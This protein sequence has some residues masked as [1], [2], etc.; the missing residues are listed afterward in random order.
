KDVD[1]SIAVLAG[2]DSQLQRSAAG[3]I[4]A[5]GEKQN[6][7]SAGGIIDVPK[8]AET[9][10]IDCIENSGARNVAASVR[11]E[12]AVSDALGERDRIVRPGLRYLRQHAEVDDERL[13][14]FLTQQPLHVP[15]RNGPVTRTSFLHGFAR[16][17]QNAGA[18]GKILLHAKVQHLTRR[19][20]VIENLQLTELQIVDRETVSIGRMKGKC[21]LI[22]R[23]AETERR[24]I[25]C[26]FLTSLGETKPRADSERKNQQA[27]KNQPHVHSAGRPFC[28]QKNLRLSYRRAPSSKA[29]DLALID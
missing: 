1:G 9:S 6:E 25:L 10:P 16:I 14:G 23:H 20:A 13:V 19:F 21:D 22:D 5:V 26:A 11:E 27:A 7:V 3:V 24:R 12:H 8:L 29:I 2:V 4:F 28:M 15:D 17:H 18:D